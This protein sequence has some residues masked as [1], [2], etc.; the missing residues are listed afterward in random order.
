[1]RDL[2][3]RLKVHKDG[4]GGGR[5]GGRGPVRHA[6]SATAAM[7]KTGNATAAVTGPAPLKQ[8]E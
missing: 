1:M 5:G 8:R 3:M 7:L 6:P 2:E 4:E